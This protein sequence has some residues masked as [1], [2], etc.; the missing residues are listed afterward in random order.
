MT[1]AVNTLKLKSAPGPDGIP[2]RLLK[3]LWGIIKIPLTNTINWHLI[4]N[5][6]PT[7][8]L[9]AKLRLIPKK[10]DSRIMK[11]WR[12]ITVLNSK[13]KLLSSAYTNRVKTVVNKIV[14]TAQKGFSSI[15]RAHEVLLNLS[16]EISTRAYDTAPSCTISFDFAAAFDTIDHDYIYAVMRFFGFPANMIGILRT[17]IGRRSA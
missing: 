12:P 15:R 4:N 10:G 5:Q 3:S 9:T 16:K 8:Y 11:N 1:R 6:L 7:D 17:M 14:G 2:A 13:Y